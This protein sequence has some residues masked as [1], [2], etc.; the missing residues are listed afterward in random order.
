MMTLEVIRIDYWN[1]VKTK[2]VSQ[3]LK[4]IVGEEEARKSMS[5]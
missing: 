4:Q 3:G 2:A 1:G 5:R